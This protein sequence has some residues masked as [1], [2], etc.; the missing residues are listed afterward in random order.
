ML[1]WCIISL[2]SILC[3]VS[4][5]CGIIIY[6]I[7]RSIDWLVIR[8]FV[9]ILY[10]VK[11][12]MVRTRLPSSLR[13]L[14]PAHSWQL[15]WWLSGWIHYFP[16]ISLLSFTSKL[17]ALA[18]WIGSF[19]ISTPPKKTEWF[20]SPKYSWKHQLANHVLQSYRTKIE[21]GTVA[22]E[23]ARRLLRA[24]LTVLETMR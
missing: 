20:F 1:G 24:G 19:K 21:G 7:D 8:V 17:L 2:L 10:H 3:T 5:L 4:V 23:R 12:G 22:C 11:S 18:V 16:S 9:Y 14:I 15:I 13:T 6:L